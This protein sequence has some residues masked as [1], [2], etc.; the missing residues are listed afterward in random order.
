MDDTRDTLLLTARQVKERT[1]LPLPT[2][3]DQAAK[4]TLPHLRIGRSVRFPLAALELW[5]KSNTL[6]VSRDDVAN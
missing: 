2:I 6:N 3:Y 1:N 5:I 4:G